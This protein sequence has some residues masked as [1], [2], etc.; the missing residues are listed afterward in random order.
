VSLVI[1]L[2]ARASLSIY[3]QNLSASK[4][5]IMDVDIAS[6]MSEFSKFQ[7][8]QQAGVAMLAQAN[9]SPQAVLK[10]LG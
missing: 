4:S 1:K 3:E 2:P 7:I 9:Q 8:M 6:E 5:Q 10:L